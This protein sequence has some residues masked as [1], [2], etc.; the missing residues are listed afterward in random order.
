MQT[1][2][3]YISCQKLGTGNIQ[4]RIKQFYMGEL[5]KYAGKVSTDLMYFLKANSQT[6]QRP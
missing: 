1:D 4:K 6:M 3:L 5:F 2:K